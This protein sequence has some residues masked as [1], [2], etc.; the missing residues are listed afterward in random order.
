[1]AKRWL[2][3]CILNHVSCNRLSNRAL[4]LPTRLI[5]L[6]YTTSAFD[7]SS[8]HLIESR[9]LAPGTKYAT[10]SHCW[11]TKTSLEL[12]RGSINDLLVHIPE[13]GLCKTF[14]DS[15]VAAKEL[16]IRYLWIDRLCIIQH[17]EEDWRTESANMQEVYSNAF[18]NIAATAARDGDDG[19][20]MERNPLLL[21]KCFVRADWDGDAERYNGLYQ[22]VTINRFLDCIEGA[23]L[24]SRG[25]VVQ[26]RYLSR[27]IL[28][29]CFQRLFWECCES[30]S[31]EVE[32]DPGS[33]FAQKKPHLAPL[34]SWTYSGPERLKDVDSVHWAW[35]FMV[36]KF[37]KCKLT[38]KSDKLP[39]I[40]GITKDFEPL[41]G[42]NVVGLWKRF[43]EYE[44]LW[45]TS[46]KH[47]D[48]EP[49]RTSFSCVP[50]WSWASLDKSIYF[51][52]SHVL[53]TVDSCGRI[54]YIVAEVL[55][56]P[57][58]ITWHVETDE[59]EKG[60]LTIKGQLIKVQLDP[61]Q[62]GKTIF[63]GI[64]GKSV[65]QICSDFEAD[66]HM[67]RK[68][69]YHDTS[70]R[71][72]YCLPI[73]SQVGGSLPSRHTVTGLL[74]EPSGTQS[75]FKRIGLFRVTGGSI[76]FLRQG[77]GPALHGGSYNNT[78]DRVLQYEFR[79]KEVTD[80]WAAHQFAIVII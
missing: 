46:S 56:M 80:I 2:N 22:L 16:G 54:S 17:D 13:T 75:S 40:A 6:G 71:T 69:Q 34:K 57:T 62:T 53:N 55:N 63:S 72:I 74:L 3:N 38:H 39:A 20:F 33:R 24:N 41:L 77:D 11:G 31:C 29:F 10:L 36:S 26:E 43:I 28:Q 37:S 30:A 68:D 61:W 44:L 14:F 73:L 25:W 51:H 59:M 12:T 35:C 42:E 65:D 60:E 66:C 8:M 32:P 50:S 78:I 47:P 5:D 4:N 21:E 19:C 27:R 45:S 18:L 15:A 23:P 64:N 48:D 76:H 49:T 52:Q 67:D 7:L 9:R 1:M 70:M 79:G 58:D